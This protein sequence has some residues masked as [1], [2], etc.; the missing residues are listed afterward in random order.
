MTQ[1]FHYDFVLP[2]LLLR[3]KIIPDE[4]HSVSLS[5]TDNFPV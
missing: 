1:T 2:H 3:L 5:L 4:V